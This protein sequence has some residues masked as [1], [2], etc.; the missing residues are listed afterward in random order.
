MDSDIKNETIEPVDPYRCAKCGSSDIQRKA[1]VNP[2]KKCEVLE[3]CG[4]E[5]ETDNNWCCECEEQYEISLESDISE[6]VNAWWNSKDFRQMEQITGYRQVDFDE[7]DS[8]H[9]FV[10]ACN[11]YWNEL[12]I[13]D[14]VSKYSNYED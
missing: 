11:K 14:K 12:S 1:W 13:E 2:N 6:T 8:F 7:Q 5:S 4:G 10:D 3:F 9:D